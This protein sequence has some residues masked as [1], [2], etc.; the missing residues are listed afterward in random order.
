MSHFLRYGRASR[1]GRKWDHLRSA[2]PVIVSGYNPM[3]VA[4]SSLTWQ[5]FVQSSA[6]G[7]RPSQDK[8]PVD[9]EILQKLQ[10]TFDHRIGIPPHAMGPESS[11]QFGLLV[12]HSRIW[13]LIFRHSLS[14][15][16]FRLAVM[17]T[18]IT[19]LGIS[20][21]IFELENAINHDSAERT[22]S[23]VAIVVD[24]LAIPY[25][26]YMIW[27]EY[28]G[29]PVG[30][31][32]GISKIRLILLD[33]FFIIFKSVSTALAFETLVYHQVEVTGVRP[34]SAALGVLMLA[35]LISWTM[36]FTVNV[37]R[38]VERLGGGDYHHGTV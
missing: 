14:P 19:A 12:L 13:Y 11:R 16:F 22:Q 32:S 36:N 7:R 5:D 2:D 21:R 6:W 28:A 9:E 27:D 26:G 35:G 24:C 34:L 23:L 20:A 10:P 15:L 17:F 18:S 31:R 25:S 1:G 29:K 37:F 30:L 4:P 8:A 33:V 3:P 38:T